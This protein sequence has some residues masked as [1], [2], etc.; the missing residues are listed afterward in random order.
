MASSSGP[1]SGLRALAGWGGPCG[2]LNLLNIVNPESR[3]VCF[4]KGC[5]PADDTGWWFALP[6][7]KWEG[8]RNKGGE[9]PACSHALRWLWKD[10]TGYFGLYLLTA[11]ASTRKLYTTFGYSCRITDF[12]AHGNHQREM[13]VPNVSVGLCLSLFS[14][15]KR[16]AIAPAGSGNSPRITRTWKQIL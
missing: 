4:S 8:R 15:Q 9:E 2:A 14:H 5:N 10:L 3:L 1:C 13:C 11:C 12:A 6:M 7:G 16:E